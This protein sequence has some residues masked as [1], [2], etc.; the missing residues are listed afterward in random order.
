M[1][2][3]EILQR[4]RKV[5]RVGDNQWEARCPA[6][7]D[8]QASLSVGRGDKDRPLLFCHAGCSFENI[9]SAL[10]G[11]EVQRDTQDFDKIP[12]KRKP[13]PTYETPKEAAL[14]YKKGE[15]TKAWWYQGEKGKHVGG[16]LRW[17][18]ETGKD[19]RPI[20]LNEYGRWVKGAM[21]EPRP[22]WNHQA[23]RQTEGVVFV[24]E[25]EK[26]AEAGREQGLVTTT[27]A[28]GAS[29]V[30]KADWTPLKGKRVVV[31]PDNDNPG[32]TWAKT[33]EKA[34]TKAE[35]ESVQIL[36]LPGL[37]PKGDLF[38]WF[39]EMGKS[40]ADLMQLVDERQRDP[41]WQDKLIHNYDKHGNACGLKSVGVNVA[42]I[43]AN[44]PNWDGVLAYNESA[45]CPMFL[46]DP[47]FHP[48]YAGT[49]KG[50]RL[51][52]DKDYSRI[53]YW[54]QEAW[55]L[56]VRS[57]EVYTAIE[58]IT[59]CNSVDPLRQY[60][61]SVQWDGRSRVSSWLRDYLDGYAMVHKD[62]KYVDMIGKW[63]LISA[64]ARALEPGCKADHVLVLE[65][66]EGIGK[67]TAFKILA[68][69]WLMDSALN[70]HN[71][72]SYINIRG[73]WIVEIPEMD[74]I[75]RSESSASK[76]FFTSSSDTY[77]A[78]YGRGSINVPRSCVFGG[79]VN[80]N[81]YIRDSS[82]GRRYW[83]VQCRKV[84]K[85]GL[86]QDRDQ[87][88][89][90]ALHLYR[91]GERWW[92][93]GDEHAFLRLEQEARQTDDPWEEAIADWIEGR[94]YVTPKDIL[95]DALQIETSKQ[96]RSDLIRV[97]VTMQ[98]LGWHR[99]RDRRCPSNPGRLMTYYEPPPSTVLFN[100]QTLN[101]IEQ[102]LNTL[103]TQ[104]FVQCSKQKLDSHVHGGA[105]TPAPARTHTSFYD[106]DI[107]H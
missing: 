40:T 70:I 106:D 55:D 82:G 74:S 17:D 104:A 43:L 101:N 15:P 38:E 53:T 26:A 95:G 12:K 21:P 36:R 10:G 8:Q 44:D 84:D 107:E 13:T 48:D 57:D 60:L 52:E 73:K 58:N 81:D 65:G 71:K 90:E 1:E 89:A 67:S 42:R 18:S 87:L 97:G 59:E 25:G 16:I 88:W 66:P 72:D 20:A 75:I 46:D 47:P 23:V 34:A 29:A 6:H 4:L 80:H 32:E 68:G 27:N 11:A 37:P 49:K 31:L 5:K 99:K 63:W 103:D 14:A 69:P 78:P 98:K 22:I 9:L 105:H 41:N 7:N 19:I 64:V 85:E 93:D 96:K 50:P 102:T 51:L 86:I 30:H 62:H 61:Q 54:L 79:S 77:R 39:H 33:L 35:A 45:R 92:P 91:Q 56:T 83:P 100:D 3:Q 28:G 24:C 76:S 2:L 94:Q